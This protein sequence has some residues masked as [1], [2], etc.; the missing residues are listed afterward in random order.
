MARQLT[1]AF[2][3][4]NHRLVRNYRGSANVL[5]FGQTTYST[6]IYLVQPSADSIPGLP[7]YEAFDSTGFAGLRVGLWS[8][9]TG[10]LSDSDEYLLAL[11]PDSGWTYNDDAP[12]YPYYEGELNF[13]TEQVADFLGSE[14]T[15]SAYFAVNLMAGT[16]LYAVFDHVNG[17]TNASLYSATDEGGGT[18]ID[19]TQIDALTGGQLLSFLR[20]QNIHSWREQ[21]IQVDEY[22]LGHCKRTYDCYILGADARG[23]SGVGTSTIL[24]LAI[25]G[26]LTGDTITLA[27]A[28][29]GEEV[30]GTFAPA[31]P[32]VL[33]TGGTTMRWIVTQTPT[34]PNAMTSLCV[35]TRIGPLSVITSASDGNWRFKDGLI[36]FW[37]PYYAA[38]DAGSPWYTLV[39]TETGPTR[40]DPIPT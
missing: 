25:D 20:E 22:L 27:T 5:E 10:T 15:G 30:T 24:S 31:S 13:Y 3:A 29:V 11:T 12:L 38:L 36:Q 2:D 8:D 40:S 23:I 18:P 14:K 33:F 34:G 17:R 16:S 4:V 35:N 19:V 37:S 9:S 21:G 6:R 7:A 39:D 26:V 32:G 1:L 28:G